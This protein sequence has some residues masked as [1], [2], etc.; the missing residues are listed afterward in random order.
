MALQLKD[1]WER[2]L[3][4][5]VELATR[6]E[7]NPEETPIDKPMPSAHLT[8]RKVGLLNQACFEAFFEAAAIKVLPNGDEA[9]AFFFC[10][11]PVLLRLRDVEGPM[12]DL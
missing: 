10:W 4:D 7:K 2:G 9:H 8:T 11:L 6:L 12:D 1:P 3:H 5:R